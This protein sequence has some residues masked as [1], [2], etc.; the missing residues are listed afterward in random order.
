MGKRRGVTVDSTGRKMSLRQHGKV[1]V[2]DDGIK[3]RKASS[4]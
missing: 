4:D 2:G 3:L 1:R